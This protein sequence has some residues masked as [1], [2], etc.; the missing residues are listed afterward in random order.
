MDLDNIKFTPQILCYNSYSIPERDE[1][2]ET[3]VK[4]VCTFILQK[5]YELNHVVTPALI[6]KMLTDV[7]EQL[8]YVV[9]K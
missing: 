6:K 9:L 7:T 4:E 3:A 1:E 2:I 5:T 8:D